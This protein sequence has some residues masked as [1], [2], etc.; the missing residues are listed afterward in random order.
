MEILIVIDS[1]F[2]LHSFNLGINFTSCLEELAIPYKLIVPRSVIEELETLAS[3]RKKFASLAIE[4]MKRYATV[5]ESE[6]EGNVDD[7]V[8]KTA[9]DYSAKVVATTDLELKKK[10]WQQGLSVLYIRGKSRY[11]LADPSR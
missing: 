1:S 10:A 3:K 11:E 2:L 9:L 4:V 5:V 6:C 7:C 8:L